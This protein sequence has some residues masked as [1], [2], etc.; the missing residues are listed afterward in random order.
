MRSMAGDKASGDRAEVAQGMSPWRRSPGWAIL[1]PGYPQ[2]SWWQRERALALF[3]SFAAALGVGLFGWGTS[4]GWAILAFAFVTHVASVADVIRQASFPGFGKWVPVLS[5]SA[6]LGL[7]CYGPGLVLGL[8]LAWPGFRGDAPANGYLINRLAYQT[9]APS[10]GDWVWWRGPD[11]QRPR[12]VRVMAG[13]G[14][15]VALSPSGWRVDGQGVPWQPTEPTDR[16]RELIFRVPSNRVLIAPAATPE[17]QV[18][19]CPSS[20]LVLIPSQ[21]IVGRA[22]ARA[23]PVWNRGLLP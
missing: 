18:E 11:G 17:G 13:P 16:A 9:A 1:I 4:A 10:A 14:Q 15:E 20:G 3:G 5:A 23:Y 22:W 7:G 19:P 21:E 6:G 2:W 8:L 12:A